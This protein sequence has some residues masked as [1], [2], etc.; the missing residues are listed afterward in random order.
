MREVG[1]LRGVLVRITELLEDGAADEA[2]AF[3]VAAA[4]EP[5]S[6]PCFVCVNCGLV[7]QWPGQLDHHLRFSDCWRQLG[8]WAASRRAA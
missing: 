7:Y 8:A 2:Y 6:H 5:T 3:A 1:R 4:E